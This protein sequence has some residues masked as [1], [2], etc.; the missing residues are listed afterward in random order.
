MTRPTTSPSEL[1]RRLGAP[2]LN[3]VWSWGAVRPA[4]GVVFLRVWQD[5]ERKVDG[6]WYTMLTHHAVFVDD[7]ANLGWQERL[8][9]LAKIR[10][11]AR[12]Y[13]VMCEAKDVEASPRAIKSFNDRDL[14]VGGALVEMDGDWWIERVGRVAVR[15]VMPKS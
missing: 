12:C 6:R 11:G 1:F 8:G 14:F 13:L 10:G 9:H 2:L 3:V 5:R 15:D 4:D 7:P